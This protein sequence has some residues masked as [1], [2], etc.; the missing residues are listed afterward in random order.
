MQ[1]DGHDWKNSMKLSFTR[2]FKDFPLARFLGV[3]LPLCALILI[4]SAALFRLEA[5][6]E[7][8]LVRM[9]SLNEIR[10]LKESIERELDAVGMDLLIHAGHEAIRRYVEGGDLE[11]LP[12]AAEELKTFVEKKGVLDQARLIDTRGREILRV[13]FNS[14]DPYIVPGSGLQDKS[15]R[16]Y[17]TETIKLRNQ[18]IYISPFDLTGR[19]A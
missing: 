17:F 15:D 2:H 4:I 11:A 10:L 13:N 12:Q 3:A 19:G 18:E 7:V 5:R 9:R 16:P 6:Q 1:I 8:E 14:G